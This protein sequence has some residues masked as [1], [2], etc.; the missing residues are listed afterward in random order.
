MILI[1]D[2]GSSKTAWRL[3]DKDGISQFLTEGLNPV[4]KSSDHLTSILR[5]Q[6][7]PELTIDGSQVGAVYFYGAGCIPGDPSERLRGVLQSLFPAASVDVYDDLL[8]VAR[9]VC[10]HKAGIACILGT[11]T[12]SCLYD[13]ENIA[14]RI[15]ALGYILGDEGGG[16]WLG[17]E[18][19]AAYL[20]N[21]LPAGIHDSFVKRFNLGRSEI[22]GS[23]YTGGHAASYLA[24]F[25]KFIFHHKEDP[26][27]YKMVYR[28]FATFLEK[29]VMRY[30]N[31]QD[32]PVH[33][34]GSIA[35]YYS[36]ILRKAAADRGVL[37]KNIVEGPIAGLT[38]Y[39]QN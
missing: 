29:N 17:K 36:S 1:A 15:P 14:A 3:I 4:H 34:S 8:A 31:F 30:D 16:A 33:F 22:L 2:S 10:G 21:E 37:V 27:L 9:G 39:Y 19:L 11:G 25:S 26:F 20:R 24:G 18:L 23:V 7:L 38:L 32:Y 6:L 5:D 28:G 35:F 12:N 13:G